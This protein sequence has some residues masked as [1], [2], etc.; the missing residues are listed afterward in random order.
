MCELHDGL[1]IQ[2]IEEM[3]TLSR[4][5]GDQGQEDLCFLFCQLKNQ[6][7]AIIGHQFCLPIS[8]SE[9]TINQ[10]MSDIDNKLQSIIDYEKN[11]LKNSVSAHNF[12]VNVIKYPIK[13][14]YNNRYAA[15][16]EILYS[17]P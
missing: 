17:R 6:Y 2:E 12:K 11:D 1:R 10:I 9:S 5:L 7:G 3:E 8:F 16:D 15:T 4:I 14:A 13:P